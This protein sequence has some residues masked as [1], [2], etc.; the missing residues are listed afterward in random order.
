MSS[1]LT[2]RSV[3][4]AG[5]TAATG[6]LAGCSALGSSSSP[7]VHLTK[8]YVANYFEEELT[9]EMHILDNGET[10][11]WETIQIRAFDPDATEKPEAD[12]VSLQELPE[13]AGNYVAFANLPNIDRDDPTRYDVAADAEDH[14]ASCAQ[15]QA[16]IEKVGPRGDLYPSIV[17]LTTGDPRWWDCPDTTESP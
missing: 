3:L 12:A 6:L 16:R 11:Y 17:F 8:G 4:R 13:T 15:L 5:G 10:A 7:E 14:D 1:E 2:R 9:V